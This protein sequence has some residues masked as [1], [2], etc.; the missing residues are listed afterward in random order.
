MLSVA[1]RHA[2]LYLTCQRGLLRLCSSPYFVCFLQGYAACPAE[3]AVT[4]EHLGPADC[5]AII[6]EV[7]GTPITFAGMPFDAYQAMLSQFMPAVGAL[8]MA[9]MF[10]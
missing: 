5:V 7:T 9:N 10:K 6:S 2:W 4:G 3:V 8:D 1:R